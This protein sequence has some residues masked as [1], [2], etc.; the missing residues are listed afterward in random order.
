MKHLS[1]SILLFVCLLIKSGHAA[2]FQSEGNLTSC[3]QG[4]YVGLVGGLSQIELK[5]TNSDFKSGYYVGGFFGYR[6]PNSFRIEGEISYQRS[7]SDHSSYAKG[8]IN[9]L[10]Y[11]ANALYEFHCTSPFTPY[12]GVGAGYAQVTGHFKNRPDEPLTFFHFINKMHDICRGK[13]ELAMQPII[14]VGYEICNGWRACL[15]YR[16]LW[17][18]DTMA[19]HKFGCSLTKQF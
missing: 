18:R 4:I 16:F 14:G 19:A 8:Y 13:N 6:F 10:S 11:M 17:V 5:N 15:E 1:I 2:C 9:T 12:L 7:E 3:D